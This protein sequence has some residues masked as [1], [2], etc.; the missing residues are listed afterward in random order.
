MYW[1]FL[2]ERVS[3][4]QEEK[5]GKLP[6]SGNPLGNFEP[7]REDKRFG[8]KGPG[9]GGKPHIKE[10]RSEV[11]VFGINLEASEEISLERSLHD[12]RLPECKYISYP[13]NLPKVSVIIV[14]ENVGLSVLIRAVQSV[15]NRSPTELLEEVLLV[16]D[17]SV[18]N[19]RYN[20]LGYIQTLDGKV[21]YMR[22][23]QKKGLLA[24][25]N[26]A[27][28]HATGSVIVFLD[29]YCEVNVNWLPPL[30][31]P[32]YS[33][34]S[35]ITVPIIDVIDPDTFEYRAMHKADEHYRGIFDW[36]LNYREHPLPRKESK[37]RQHASD[38]YKS[39]TH[40]GSLLA[41]SRDFFVSSGGYDV[42]LSNWGGYNLD[43]SF[44]SW[45]C[46]RGILWV[47]CSRVGHIFKGFSSYYSEI[48]PDVNDTIGPTHLVNLKR[49]V[50]TWLDIRYK[51]NVYITMPLAQSV[52]PGELL[53]QLSLKRKLKCRSFEWFMTNV[54]SG[55]LDVYPE[56]PEN[57]HWGQ[58]INKKL[59]ECM[60]EDR[61]RERGHLVVRDCTDASYNCAR[62]NSKGQLALDDQCVDIVENNLRSLPCPI[63]TVEGP[64]EYKEEARTLF[65]RKHEKCI[66][67]DLE[68]KLVLPSS[69]NNGNVYQKWEFED[70]EQVW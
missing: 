1:L 48:V 29:G 67:L 61:Y 62:L 7:K 43:L 5:K 15:V 51:K 4:L 65:H 19:L 17:F 58:L 50:E 46:G 45:Q 39:P 6:I 12:T 20:I 54:A 37:S 23:S 49:V 42:A 63:G 34:E 40:S 47:P 68:S 57:I 53:R 18:V 31:S 28:K 64:W 14:F 3:K 11:V 32:I 24:A 55:V 56:P 69:C 36:G 59:L 44:K 21:K 33:N 8:M 9:E 38:P 27:A 13:Q 10:K 25:R 66:S 30:L 2:S 22:Y 52:A 16:D 41:V 26:H 60:T 35:S 70:P